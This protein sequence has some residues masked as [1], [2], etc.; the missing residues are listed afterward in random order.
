MNT[1]RPRPSRQ[2]RRPSLT[3][4]LGRPDSTSIFNLRAHQLLASPLRFEP[5]CSHALYRPEQPSQPTNVNPLT[6]LQD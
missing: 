6:D 4:T 3:A 1:I 2:Q 5:A